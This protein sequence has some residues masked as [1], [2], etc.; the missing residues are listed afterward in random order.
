MRHSYSIEFPILCILLKDAE[1]LLFGE[2]QS[3]VRKKN[4]ISTIFNCFFRTFFPHFS[5]PS[6]IYERRF[7][8]LTSKRNGRTGMNVFVEPDN[9]VR[10]R[11]QW[12][13]RGQQ[14]AVGNNLQN[15]PSLLNCLSMGQNRLSVLK[16]KQ[17]KKTIVNA[18]LNCE[19][20]NHKKL[21]FFNTILITKS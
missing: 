20:Y 2:E 1:V 3:S 4:Y 6:L 18:S 9:L 8:N 15:K 17:I 16:T 11:R 12:K 10:Y 21:L 14:R 7:C 19:Q 13:R 5:H